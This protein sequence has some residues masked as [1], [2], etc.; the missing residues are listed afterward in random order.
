VK[1][2]TKKKQVKPHKSESS[3]VDNVLRDDT[4]AA[5]WTV[6]RL[7]AYARGRMAEADELEEK[8]FRYGRRSVQEFWAAGRALALIRDKLKPEK[9]KW[10]AWQNTCGLSRNRVNQAIRLAEKAKGMDDL[11]DFDTIREALVHY[12]I[13]KPRQPTTPQPPAG[14]PQKRDDA[15]DVKG[16]HEDEDKGSAQ[17]D[18]E[19][20]PT[21]PQ[22]PGV[23]C[24]S[25][26]LRVEKRGKKTSF[27]LEDVEIRMNRVPPC[28]FDVRIVGRWRVE[29]RAAL[30]R[31][32]AVLILPGL[33]VP[34]ATAG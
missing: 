6:E 9:N 12:E 19:Q 11:K 34:D 15:A 8:A 21:P 23:P 7:A 24:V 4:P 2:K 17:K 30:D 31:G 22:D 29:L 1:T 27:V 20:S 18:E 28:K 14:P 3:E 33:E 25:G 5:D 26:K 13:E 10:V 16:E 32:E